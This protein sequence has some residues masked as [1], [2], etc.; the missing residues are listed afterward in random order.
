MRK[1]DDLFAPE[2]EDERSPVLLLALL[3]IGM[4][5]EMGAVE[6]TEAVLILRKVGGDPVEQDADAGLVQRIDEEHEIVRRS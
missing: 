6:I 5:E 2:V 3:G 4:F 1:F